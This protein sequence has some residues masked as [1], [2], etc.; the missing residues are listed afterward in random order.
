MTRLDIIETACPPFKDQRPG[1]A[2]LRKKVSVFSQPHY[3]EMFAQAVLTTLRLPPGARIVIGGDGRYFNDI[4]IH[5][6]IA[7][8]VGNG[9]G[10]IIVGQ[11]GLLSTPAASH[12]IRLRKADAGFI[13]TASHNPGGPSGDFGLK[14]N[15]ANGGQAP[16]HITDEVFRVSTQ[17]TGY[18]TVAL[19]E[20]DLARLA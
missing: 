2:G 16:E 19:P 15:T 3:L 13:L 4:A 20:L 18:R 6:L 7:V 8:A 14:F 1:T 10:E 11:H 17:Q 9:V 5:K 12:L